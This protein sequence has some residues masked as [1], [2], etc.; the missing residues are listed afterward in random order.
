PATRLEPMKPA[1]PVTNNIAH[2]RQLLA[3]LCPSAFARATS[4]PKKRKMAPHRPG[5]PRTPQRHYGAHW[6]GTKWQATGP[7]GSSAR[8]RHEGGSRRDLAPIRI[9]K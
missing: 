2:L 3:P 8:L 6:T 5:A 9:N 4:L 1:P 7:S